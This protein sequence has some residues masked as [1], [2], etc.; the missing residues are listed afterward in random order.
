MAILPRYQADVEKCDRAFALEDK[1]RADGH[2]QIGPQKLQ[3][4]GRQADCSPG[5]V[6]Q[7]AVYHLDPAAARLASMYHQ[8]LLMA[9][10]SQRN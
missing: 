6:D 7:T 10:N 1:R 2:Q 4:P 8:Q 9:P 3:F 5:P